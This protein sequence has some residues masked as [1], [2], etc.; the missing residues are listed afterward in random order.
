MYILENKKDRSLYLNVNEL[1]QVKRGE[2][3]IV[4]DEENDAMSHLVIE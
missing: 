4:N 2:Y 3:M 1:F